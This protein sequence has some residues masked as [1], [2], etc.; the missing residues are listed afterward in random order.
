VALPPQLGFGQN[1]TQRGGAIAYSH[2]LT[3]LTNLNASVSRYQTIA[4]APSNVKSVTNY[5]VVSAGTRL[6]PRTDGSM[7]LTYSDFESNVTNDYTAF[8]VFVGLNHR[9]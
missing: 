3:S 1:N 4:T 2:Q 6:G 5:F 7:G 9:F 8:T